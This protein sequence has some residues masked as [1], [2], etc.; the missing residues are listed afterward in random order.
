MSS[1]RNEDFPRREALNGLFGRVPH[2]PKGTKITKHTYNAR[3]ETAA[4]LNAPSGGSMEHVLDLVE[5]ACD[6]LLRH[7]IQTTLQVTLK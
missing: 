5:D 3:S 1:H 2:W 4:W 6:G 7:L